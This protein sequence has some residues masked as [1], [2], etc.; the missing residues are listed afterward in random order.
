MG[1][2]IVADNFDSN[3]KCSKTSSDGKS[4]GGRIRN[5]PFA[6]FRP[7]FR[8]YEVD[9]RTGQIKTDKRR[10]FMCHIYVF[11]RLIVDDFAIS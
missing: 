1:N 11:I 9:G 8:V 10:S 7:N 3:W 6:C 2:V 5:V 4:D